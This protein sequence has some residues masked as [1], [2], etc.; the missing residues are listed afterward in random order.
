M[1][2]MDTELTRLAK[3][4]EILVEEAHARVV[5]KRSFEL[6][7]GLPPTSEPL[8]PSKVEAEVARRVG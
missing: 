4:G 3:D 8:D 5:D 6:A 1:Q 7:L 2:L